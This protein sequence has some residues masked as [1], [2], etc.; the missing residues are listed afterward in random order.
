MKSTFFTNNRRSLIK[1]LHG[2][3]VVLA[4]YQSLQWTGDQ[5]V[6]FRQEANFWYLTGISEPGW[7]IVIEGASA[8]SWLVRPRHTKHQALFDGEISD[9]EVLKISGVENIIPAESLP[10][11]IRQLA[12]QHHL[13]YTHI[14][15]EYENQIGFLPNPAQ[16][17][18][19]D[20]LKRSFTNVQ[21][22]TG[23]LSKLRS[24]KQP[25]ELVAIKKAAR[26]TVA[27]HENIIKNIDKYKYEYEIEADLTRDFRFKGA[28]GNAYEPIVASGINACVLHY[29]K[30][31]DRLQKGK[32]ILVDAAAKFDNYSVDLTRTYAYGNMTNR[33]K[34]IHDTLRLAQAEIIKL[35]RPGLS[36]RDLQNE[37]DLIMREVIN[38][39]GLNH[40]KLR[41]YYPHAI[42][43][44]I[45]IDTHDPIGYDVISSGMVLTI[46]PG[47]YIREEEIGIRIEDT[48]VVSEKSSMNL[49][50]KLTHMA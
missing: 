50:N 47:I 49:T 33:F 26:I 12:R 22:C 37:S 13:A 29:S 35:I 38:Q 41:D 25:E 31:N 40:E 34:K 24:I 16:R 20:M 36:L 19:I 14:P 10:D 9:Q 5:S 21:S 7:Q 39:L 8:K 48:I 17:Q 2:G 15:N 28:D 32:Y 23:E 1:K 18:L 3:I 30:N 4:G 27:A 11:L 44:G 43:H 42:G 6:P 46:E 45:G